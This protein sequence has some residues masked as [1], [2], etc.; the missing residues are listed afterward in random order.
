[1]DT[2]QPLPDPRP[3][4]ERA[5]D[6]MAALIDLTSKDTL[7][8]PTPC[9][10]YD[11]RGLVSHV[12]GGTRL[13]VA[14]GETGGAPGV[15]DED[16]EVP[17]DGL[18]EAYAA[19]RRRLAAAWADD[20]KLDTVVTVPWGTMP[21]RYALSGSVMETVMH[22]W[23]LSRALGHPIPLDQELAAFA[24]G[25]ARQALPAEGREGLP[26]GAVVP[27][28]PAENDTYAQLAGWLGRTP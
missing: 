11:V 9:T 12:I 3:F 21:G 17:D 28:G 27:V 24:L 20:A 7:D 19:E 10:E 1:M 15:R 14:V 13:F 22:S 4:Y 8:E 18:A 26:F 25:T 2:A 6:Q 16:P 23:D 5:A